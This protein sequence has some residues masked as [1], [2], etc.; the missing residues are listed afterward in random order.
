MARAVAAARRRSTRARGRASPTPSA[1]ATSAPSA[2]RCRRT[3]ADLGQAWTARVGHAL[4]AHAVLRDDGLDGLRV[5]RGTG[6]HVPVRGARA[7]V[8]R[9]RVRSARARAGRRRRARS[10]RGT[11]RSSSS[12]TRSGPRCSPGARSSSSS[13]P[14]APGEGYLVA[15]AARGDRAPAGRAQRGDRRPRGLRAARA[16][17]A[18][19]QDHVHRFHRRGP[20][21][22]A[23]CAASASPASRSSSAASRPRSSSTT[24]TSRRWRRSIA[25]A[26]CMMTGQVCSSLTRIVVTQ[27][28]PR[29]DGRGTRRHLRPGEGRRPVR[30]GRARW[31][32]WPCSASATASRATS[33]RASTRARRSRPVVAARRTS[34]AAGSS[35][36]PCSATSTTRRPSPRRRS[37]GRC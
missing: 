34:T 9:R 33:P 20:Q 21:D 2:P 14:E 3:T 23:R 18:R 8:V 13:S 11:R 36:R 25:G 7:A 37:S 6:R 27:E 32:R 22:R 29:R 35:S 4:R 17:P 19:R 28:A 15:E 30:R 12:R 24:P 5:V 10:S 1:P 31:A 16:R 26:E